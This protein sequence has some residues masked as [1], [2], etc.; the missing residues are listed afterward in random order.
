[1]IRFAVQDTGEGISAENLPRIFDRFFRVPGSRA[2]EGVGLGLAITREIV[3]A[4]GG[5][6]E[7]SSEPGVGTTF[8]FTLPIASGATTSGE[9]GSLMA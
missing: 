5:Q 9:V 1:M 4:S 2:W 7:V 8:Q 3:T 6:I